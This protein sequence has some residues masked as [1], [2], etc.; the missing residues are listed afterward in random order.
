MY[1]IGQVKNI[2]KDEYRRCGSQAVVEM[3][4]EN[5]NITDIENYILDDADVGKY[6]LVQYS[7]IPGSQIMDLSICRILDDKEGEK[8][9]KLHKDRFEKIKNSVIGQPAQVGSYR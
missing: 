8:I 2:Q 5:I 9:W 1:H 3:W 4:D 6:V 7:P